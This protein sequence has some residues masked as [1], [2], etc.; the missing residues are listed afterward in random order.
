MSEVRE[1][2]VYDGD[3]DV[4]R[5]WVEYW[6]RQTG[7]RVVYRPYQEAA[8]DFQL[9]H[10]G[11]RGWWWMY[12]HVPGFAPASERAYAFFAHRRGLLR[13]LSWLLWGPRLEPESYDIVSWVFCGCSARSTSPRLPR[14][15]CK[16]WA[17]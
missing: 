12:E 13:R 16:S 15:A 10:A 1:T 2:L 3:C 17:S 6:K 5:Y 9:R 7:G 4:C 14:S 11:A 8:S